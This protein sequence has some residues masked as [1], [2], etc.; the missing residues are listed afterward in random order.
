MIGDQLWGL[1]GGGGGAEGCPYGAVD[2]VYHVM[3]VAF[4]FDC[5]FYISSLRE[6]GLREGGELGFYLD[7]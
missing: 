5:V 6:G 4:E 3:F 7:F 1:H 2:S